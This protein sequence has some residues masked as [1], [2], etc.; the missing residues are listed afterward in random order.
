[1]SAV[2]LTL[3]FVCELAAIGALVW[4]GWPV[5][6]V[7]LGL[8]VI[9]VWAVAVAPKSRRRLPD[10][11]RFAIELVIFGCATAAFAGV[12]HPVLAVVFAVAAVV[13]AGL[14]RVWPEP[15]DPA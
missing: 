6:G 13:T 15:V 7:V 2:N 14:V 9:A 3:R 4:W 5:L 8:A 11:S 10:P 12:G 1:M